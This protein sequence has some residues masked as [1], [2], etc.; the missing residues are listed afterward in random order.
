VKV[1]PRYYEK[2]GG[3]LAYKKVFHNAEKEFLKIMEKYN[4]PYE[5]IGECL[6][7]IY[8]YKRCF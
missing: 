3:Q 6:Y 2:I 1:K 8:G 5:K 7:I 4:I